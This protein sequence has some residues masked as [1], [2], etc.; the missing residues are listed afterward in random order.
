MI[1]TAKT[2]AKPKAKRIRAK[3]ATPARSARARTTAKRKTPAKR[4]R[5]AAK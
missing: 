5:A 2:R 4:K 1:G 3:S